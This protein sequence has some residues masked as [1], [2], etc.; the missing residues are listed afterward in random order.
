MTKAKTVKVRIA[1]A[2][3]SNEEWSAVGWDDQSPDQCATSAIQNLGGNN[4]THVVF[5]DAVVPVPRQRPKVVKGKV[6]KGAKR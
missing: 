5:V 2:V 3:D 1:V 6:A 4:P